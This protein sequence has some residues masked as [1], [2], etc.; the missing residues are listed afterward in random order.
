[1]KKACL[2]V[3]RVY[4]N[5]QIF[6]RDSYLNRDLGQQF[7]HDLQDEFQKRGVEL[8][9]HDILSK[10]KADFVLYN[11][12][13][14][15]LPPP[16]DKSKSYLLLFE[17]EIIR[18]DNWDLSKHSAFQKVFT[19]NTTLIGTHNYFRMNF[20]HMG[21]VPFLKFSEK[22][23]FCTLIAGH[24]MVTHPLELYSK[25]VEAIRWF[26]KNQ[27]EDFEFYG[28]GWDMHNF[29]F[30]IVSKV[31]NRVKP[32]RRY[33]ADS[34]PSYR[35]PVNRKLE[36]LKDYK[37]S[38]CYENGKDVPG[39][40]TEKIFDSMAAGCIPIYWGSPD[41]KKFIS[42]RCYVDQ[43]KFQSY[44]DLYRYLKNMGESEYNERLVAI[45][46]FL[47]SEIHSEYL[48]LNNAQNVAKCILDQ[49]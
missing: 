15:F 41:V 21:Q 25:R 10:Q 48:P 12:M 27:P 16:Q 17:S 22:K 4:R 39:Y 49:K 9:T 26:E 19:W 20:S 24:K 38:I 2:V 5:N 28:M 3:Q 8:K 36:V 37:F 34:W 31:L 29:T 1:M 46:N 6:N 30:P 18:P 35:G 47:K 42:E 14:Q 43:E 23:K 40:I 7:Y 32:L 13:P 33:L 44:E 11:E 45:E